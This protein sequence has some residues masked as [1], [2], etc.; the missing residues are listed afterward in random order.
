MADLTAV[1]D[2][3]IAGDSYR[4]TL[5]PSDY[6]AT[7]GWSLV[8]TIAGADVLTVTSTPSGDAHVLD[9]TESQTAA[10]AAGAYRWAVR[11]K[12][13]GESTTYDGGALSVHA[14]L[15]AATPGDHGGYWERMLRLCRTAREKLLAGEMREYYIDG[16]RVVLH[17]LAD[18]DRTE[19]RAQR[20]LDAQRRGS[21]FQRR[22]VVFTRT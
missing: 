9:L 11:A 21:S 18:I 16:R 14:D 22:G 1:P 19:A 3:L 5:S 15:A 8:L 6:P 17:S 7:A 20:Q 13:T 10:L 2:R 12:K 4:I